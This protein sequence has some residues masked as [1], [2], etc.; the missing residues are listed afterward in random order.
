MLSR[1]LLENSERRIEEKLL[2]HLDRVIET[3]CKPADDVA[4]KK[5]ETLL[6][7]GV[8][9]GFIAGVAVI[10]TAHAIIQQEDNEEHV[11][12]LKLGAGLLSSALGI[13]GVVIPA[14]LSKKAYEAVLQ[15]R[16]G[17]QTIEDIPFV[18]VRNLPEVHDRVVYNTIQTFFSGKGLRLRDDA[19]IADVK[20]QLN[21]L[22]N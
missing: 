2:T 8:V 20:Y 6:P 5:L 11:L 7:P 15:T 17:V 10:A 4:Q 21:L 13:A 18:A 22:A 12:F 19:T 9:L 3:L 14:W 1:S 16:Y